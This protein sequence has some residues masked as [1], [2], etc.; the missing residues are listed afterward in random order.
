[1]SDFKTKYNFPAGEVL[2]F[3]KD[4]EW[5]SFDLVQRVRNA[6]CRQLGIKKLKVGHAGTLDPL[7]TGL[8]ILCTGKATKK[9]ES[10]QQEEK[11]YVATLKLGATTPSFDM[12]T[13]EDNLNDFSNVTKISIQQTIEKFIGEIEQVPPVFSAVKVK[14]KRAFEYARKG[15]D[16]KLQPKIIVIKEIKLID[17]NPPFVTLKVTCGKGTYI[18]ALARDIGKDLGCGAYLTSLRRTRIGDFNVDNAMK[19]DFFLENIKQYVTQ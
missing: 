8:M 10:F 7:A 6:L 13:G 15:E 18:R 19:I 5:T 3:D 4:L 14:G 12:E 9:I 17:F 16:L 11:V 2:L 1:M